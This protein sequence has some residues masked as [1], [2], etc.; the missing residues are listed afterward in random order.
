MDA[1]VAGLLLDLLSRRIE[2]V[3]TALEGLRLQ[4][5][6]YAEELERRFIRRTT[7]RLEEREY[8]AMRED[9]F[10]RRRGLYHLDAKPDEAAGHGRRP[11]TS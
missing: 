8:T 6:G 1:R 7:L 9:G 3:E 10:D 4:Y 11:S 5:P 2:L